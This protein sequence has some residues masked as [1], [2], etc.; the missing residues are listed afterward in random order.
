[1]NAGVILTVNSGATLEVAGQ[2]HS[3]KGGDKYTGLTAG[4]YAEITLRANA[5]INVNSGTIKCTGY[6]RSNGLNDGSAVNAVNSDIYMPFVICDFRG[7][8]YMFAA[9]NAGIPIFSQYELVNMA[10]NVNLDYNS[11]IITYVNAT[12]NNSVMSDIVYFAGNTSDYLFQ[13]TN[14]SY[15]SISMTFTSGTEINVVNLYGGAKLNHI[16]VTSKILIFDI[17]ISSEDF[18]LPISWMWNIRLLNATGQTGA[19]YDFRQDIKMLPGSELYVGFGVTVD[20]A[21]LVIYDTYTDR[22]GTA[23]NLN[24]P[25]NKA[26]AKFGMNGTM[27]CDRVLGRIWASSYQ[28]EEGRDY[29]GEI[30]S[31][32]INATISGTGVPEANG[33]VS[34]NLMSSS[35]S[36]IQSTEAASTCEFKLEASLAMDNDNY[37]EHVYTYDGVK[38]KYI[39]NECWNLV[40]T[41]L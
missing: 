26:G 34:G 28:T 4:N 8:S 36:T 33:E 7:G 9:K 23:T 22:N 24:Y 40:R 13:M 12:I 19:Y 16:S 2:L 15:S 14:S 6:I 39:L 18:H 29:E 38:C 1:M 37:V 41:D 5:K 27:T 30:I 35:I 3:Y 31:I 20:F 25:T 10:I 11:S 21:D 17:T 32:T